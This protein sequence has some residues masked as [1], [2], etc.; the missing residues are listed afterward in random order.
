MNDSAWRHTHNITITS[1]EETLYC[2]VFVVE[3]AAFTAEGWGDY[4]PM[5]EQGEGGLWW[6]LEE[7]GNCTW[8]IREAR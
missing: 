8:N 5:A 1:D 7:H 3:G 4:P 2:P 6:L